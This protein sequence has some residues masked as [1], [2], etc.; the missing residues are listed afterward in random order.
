[1]IHRIKQKI[2]PAGWSLLMVFVSAVILGIVNIQYTKHVDDK[3]SRELKQAFCP[4][5]VLSLDNL[6]KKTIL[7]DSE[8]LGLRFMTDIVEEFDCRDVIANG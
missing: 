4:I 6:R 1:M 3:S 7:T 5:L 2:T 8:K